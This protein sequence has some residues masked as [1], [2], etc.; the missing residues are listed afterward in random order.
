[1]TNQKAHLAHICVCTVLPA[2]TVCE[3]TQIFCTVIL[4]GGF[5]G[6]GRR[7]IAFEGVC[8]CCVVRETT[9]V[10]TQSAMQLTLC[11]GDAALSRLEGDAKCRRRLFSA[12]MRVPMAAVLVALNAIL[13]ADQDTKCDAY[14]L[15]LLLRRY[16]LED[17]GYITA[18]LVNHCGIEP[19]EDFFMTA[20]DKPSAHL[21]GQ[22]A[23]IWALG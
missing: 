15:F 17:V 16:S 6:H 13:S 2:V 1:M 8:S 4:A 12:I 14:E 18:Y 21:S 22:C 20:A 10:I 7:R 3:S 11:G 9:A 23:E 19:D 5:R